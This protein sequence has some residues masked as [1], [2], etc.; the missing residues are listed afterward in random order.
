MRGKTK[1]WLAEEGRFTALYRECAAD[2]L[3]Y[4]TRRVWDS[5]I[6]MD[7]TAET[8]AHALA[9]RAQFKGSDVDAARAWI[10]SIAQSK[11]ARF[12]RDGEIERRALGRFGFEP[13]ELSEEEF[14]RVEELAGSERRREA[15]RRAMDGLSE[16]HR[17]VLELRIVRELGYPEIAER[18]EV[19][20]QTARARVSR[21][22]SALARRIDA[23]ESRSEGAA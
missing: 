18:L 9:K 14:R 11:L 4:L 21:G 10:Y 6:A 12:Y 2:L 15:V 17:S 5:Q 20:E 19:S 13:P 7:L 3:V 23:I 22:L 8:F 1:A 16:D